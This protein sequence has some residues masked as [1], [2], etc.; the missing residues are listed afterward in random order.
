MTLDIEITE[1]ELRDLVFAKLQSMLGAVALDPKDV[2]IEVKT[3]QN[4]RAKEWE[5]GQFRAR[6][7]LHKL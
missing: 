7:S 5:A 4:Y 6:V 3:T 2:K 1:N